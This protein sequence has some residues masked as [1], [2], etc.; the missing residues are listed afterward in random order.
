LNKDLVELG[1][2][3]AAQGIKG[4]VRIDSYTDFPEDIVK[5]GKLRD[6]DG[7]EYN[8]KITGTKN[9]QIIAFID[10]V[11]DRTGAEKLA[12][13]SLYVNRSDMP[14]PEKGQYYFHDLE[15]LVIR[16]LSGTEIGKI[17]AVHNF[18][19][20]S[21]IEWVKEDGSTEMTLFKPEFFPEVDI[22]AGY[23]IINE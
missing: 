20:G 15:G 7:R 13:I 18:G 23:A 21:V 1:K 19:A 22:N 12:G 10:G 16:N 17:V 6:K 9:R 3:V 2:I 5:Y 8:I 11:S 14:E 4:Q